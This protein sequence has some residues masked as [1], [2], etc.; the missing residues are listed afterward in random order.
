[1]LLKTL[2]FLDL[3][4][5]F[6]TWMF[7]PAVQYYYGHVLVLRMWIGYTIDS[8]TLFLVR[9]KNHVALEKY[10]I[11]YYMYISLSLTFF[12]VLVPGHLESDAHLLLL[13]AYFKATST[14]TAAILYRYSKETK[15]QSWFN[16][17]CVWTSCFDLSIN[18]AQSIVAYILLLMVTFSSYEGTMVYSQIMS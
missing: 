8:S 11:G 4:S 3:F 9:F 5:Y 15:D 18:F 7:G 6:V 2:L 10:V 14:L 1:M 16:V 13:L 12:T 17:C